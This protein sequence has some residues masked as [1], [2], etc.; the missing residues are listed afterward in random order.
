MAKVATEDMEQSA[1]HTSEENSQQTN[2]EQAVKNMVDFQ[3]VQKETEG[4]LEFPDQ[5]RLNAHNREEKSLG[6][7]AMVAEFLDDNKPKMSPKK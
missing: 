5:V 6:H 3:E 4:M 1:R 7:V 2:Q